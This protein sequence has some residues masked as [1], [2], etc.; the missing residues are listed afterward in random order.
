MSFIPSIIL[1]KKGGNPVN[2]LVYVVILPVYGEKC[3]IKIKEKAH[4]PQLF[5]R[6]SGRPGVCPSSLSFSDPHRSNY[7]LDFNQFLL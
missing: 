4:K 6:M 3:H 5:A 7:L 1:V 2:R